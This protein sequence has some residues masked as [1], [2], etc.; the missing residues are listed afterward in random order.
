MVAI[1][2]RFDSDRLVI[3]GAPQGRFS[4]LS[5]SE[6]IIMVLA[7]CIESL[8]DSIWKGWFSHRLW[9]PGQL[10]SR[11]R[12]ASSGQALRVSILNQRFSRRLFRWDETAGPGEYAP[13]RQ[14]TRAPDLFRYA[15]RSATIGSTWVA[16]QPGANAAAS[17]VINSS[18]EAT[19]RLT[20]SVGRTPTSMLVTSRAS[21]SLST[22]PT[23]MP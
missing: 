5:S 12:S 7:L 17:A 23:A 18:N 10:F 14:S 21:R 19:P 3:L 11:P 2:I 16:L 1:T 20:G 22:N 15:D 4:H 9:R 6:R 13:S 8:R